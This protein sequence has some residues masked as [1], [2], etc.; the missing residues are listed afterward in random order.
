MEA[1][2]SGQIF[3]FKTINDKEYD[4]IK[5]YAGNPG[6]SQYSFKFNMT[7]LIFSILLINGRNVL[8]TREEKYQDFFDL[9]NQLPYNLYKKILNELMTLRGL[10]T[11]LDAYVEGFSYTDFSRRV[12][13]TLEKRSLN[14]EEFTG[15]LGTDKMGL[16]SYQETWISINKMLD[17]EEEFNKFF[18]L[19]ILIASSSN[20]K[21]ARLTRSRHDADIQATKEKRKK[22]AREGSARKSINW[23]EQGWAAPVDTAEELVAE[24]ERQMSGL[25][26][27]HDNFIDA[28]MSNLK[29]ASEK[30]ALEATQKLE[31]ARKKNAG[32]APLTGTQRILT[33]EENKELLSRRQPNNLVI[34]PSD[35]VAS[36][37]E[38]SRYLKKI[39]SKVLT[40]RK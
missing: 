33:P 19:A 6:G 36:D 24:L 29:E 34:V 26:D 9:F 30:K 10:M 3:T 37:E 16:N 22:L 17:E 27:R 38:K 11:E 21:G 12:W 20:H 8:I 35:Q 32:M 7:F 18:S 15:I 2:L 39:G 1:E 23:S 14:N 13:K 31:E 4:L 5:L 40:A 28:Y 25:K